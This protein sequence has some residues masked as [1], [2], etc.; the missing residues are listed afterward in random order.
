MPAARS[1]CSH[2]SNREIVAGGNGGAKAVNDPHIMVR[3]GIVLMWIATALVF[4]LNIVAAVMQDRFLFGVGLSVT[5][6]Y[7]LE[8]I[9]IGRASDGT[10]DTNVTIVRR[11][12][13]EQKQ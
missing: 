8:R 3:R 7:A 4:G 10:R 6:L 2:H 13:L 11:H 9:E 12:Q 5:A 1:H